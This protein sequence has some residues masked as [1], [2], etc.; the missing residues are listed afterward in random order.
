LVSG[1]LG[2]TTDHLAELCI[3]PS[4]TA[5]PQA[6][7]VLGVDIDAALITLAQAQVRRLQRGSA[8][9]PPQ[10]PP[11]AKRAKHETTPTLQFEPCD[12]PRARLDLADAERHVQLLSKPPDGVE[13]DAARRA[14]ETQ[15]RGKAREVK[16]L[17]RV[18]Q[19]DE[20]GWD[21]VLA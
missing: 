5:L 14:R 4:A 3:P 10:D 19:Q 8:A 13:E 7:H 9:R 17:Q 11:E 18:L 16:T 1:L 21:C 6:E 12:W 2:K 20:S 15:V